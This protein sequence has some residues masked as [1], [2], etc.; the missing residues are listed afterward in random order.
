MKSYSMMAAALL[1]AT[2][3]FAAEPSK[4][5]GVQ[6]PSS[7][8]V[9]G[10][11]VVQG[12]FKS[13]GRLK[14][15][16]NP[17]WNSLSGC[18]TDI[19]AAKGKAVAGTMGGNQCFCGDEYPPEAARVDDSN[20]NQECNGFPAEACQ[21]PRYDSSLLTRQRANFSFPGGGAFFWTIYNT[22]LTIAVKTSPDSILESS[23]SSSST[24]STPTKTGMAALASDQS[25][26]NPPLTT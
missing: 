2:S 16:S 26:F 22:G 18:A 4:T 11:P 9:L 14:F 10:L 1:A 3:A 8:P 20:C 5:V 15:D 24:S 17:Q 23:S 6:A 13:K 7:K 21:S 25:N 12:C 19:C